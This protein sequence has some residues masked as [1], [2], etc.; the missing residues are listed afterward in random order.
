MKQ[1]NKQKIYRFYSR[2]SKWHGIIDY[3]SLIFIIFYVFV[4]IKILSF[5]TISII[6]KLY[7][8]IFLV[9]PMLIFT[10]LNI[11]EESITDK[12]IIILKFFYNK[13]IYIKS[14][15]YA[16]LGQKYVKNITKK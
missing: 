9:L 7:I 13:K 3:K 16:K 11:N 10:L 15:R 12:M 5:L 2:K 14:K 4:I 8:F 6:I 1:I